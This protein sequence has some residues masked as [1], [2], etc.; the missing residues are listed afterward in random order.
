MGWE[1]AFWCE[2]DEFCRRILKYWFKN[3]IG[4]EDITTQS[5]RQWRGR[6]DIL[7][8]GFPC[9]PFSTAGKRNGAEDDRYLW[10]VVYRAIKDIRPP[11]FVGEN[12]NGITSMVQPG[13]ETDV[14]SQASLFEADYKET[15]LCEEYVTET[16]CRDLESAGADGRGTGTLWD[17]I[18]GRLSE[19]NKEC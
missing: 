13:K 11:W 19:R 8:A 18:S 3:S 2:N 5:F 15:V 6:I 14:E 10:P 4:Y 16:I 17:R 7:T 1:N 9:Q 12:V